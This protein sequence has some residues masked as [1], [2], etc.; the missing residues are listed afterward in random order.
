MRI[1]ILLALAIGL[2]GCVD[3][4]IN[5]ALSSMVGRNISYAMHKLG[6]PDAKHEVMGDTIYVWATN[7]DL[8]SPIPTIKVTLQTTSIVYGTMPDYDDATGTALPRATF[9]CT[10]Q[11]A[12]NS[13]GTIKR[14]R[15]TGNPAGCAQYARALSH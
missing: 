10:I 4:R 2:S 12:V 8:E 5:K 11:L 1:S 7:D 13:S 15:W 14:W 3:D 6:L 9:N